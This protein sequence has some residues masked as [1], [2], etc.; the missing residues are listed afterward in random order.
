MEKYYTIKD[1]FHKYLENV[2]DLLLVVVHQYSLIS[3]Q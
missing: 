1:F 3:S 2:I